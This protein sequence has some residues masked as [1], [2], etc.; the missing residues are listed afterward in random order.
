[1]DV[2]SPQSSQ[3]SL[4]YFPQSSLIR[5]PH[6]SSLRQTF[7]FKHIPNHVHLN[8]CLQ[9]QH[10]PTRIVL[11]YPT[12]LLKSQT[13]TASPLFRQDFSSSIK[14][15]SDQM[16]SAK[17]TKL[18][19]SPTSASSSTDT[20]QSSQLKC[21]PSSNI[22]LPL[23]ST[24]TSPCA[25]TF[26]SSPTPT[27]PSLFCALPFASCHHFIPHPPSKV[28]P[29]TP[30]FSLHVEQHVTQKVQISSPAVP[31]VACGLIHL[32]L[33]ANTTAKLFLAGIL[34]LLFSYN[35]EFLLGLLYYPR[36][37]FDIEYE[38][39]LYGY[40]SLSFKI[41]GK[42]L[43]VTLILLFF[44]FILRMPTRLFLG[45]TNKK[46]FNRKNSVGRKCCR[47]KV[48][49]VLPMHIYLSHY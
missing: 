42:V 15:T 6:S 9:H 30:D 41:S 29:A 49:K 17:Q 3:S 28:L 16:P 26:P 38:D 21:Q 40:Y 22:L 8:Y 25:P 47:L 10:S 12:A 4:S 23:L 5:S 27:T 36:E 19:T 24:I 37:V 20:H 39:L 14:T 45:G 13:L 33:L 31:H 1:M 34:F 43:P 7:Q 46:S 32:N 11:N 44:S 48:L 2:L 35:F 18:I